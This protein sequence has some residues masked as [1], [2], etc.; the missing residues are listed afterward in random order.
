[1]CRHTFQI[2]RIGLVR[3]INRHKSWQ[4]NLWWFPTLHGPGYRFFP[5][6]GKDS[7]VTHVCISLPWCLA[8]RCQLWRQ[9]WN[10][11]RCLFFEKTGPGSHH[12]C[13]NTV[14][15]IISSDSSLDT[16]S[17]MLCEIKPCSY[18]VLCSLSSVST[19]HSSFLASC[20]GEPPFGF[21]FWKGGVDRRTGWIWCTCDLVQVM[22]VCCPK[23]WELSG[24]KTQAG[25]HTS[26]SRL[27]RFGTFQVLTWYYITLVLLQRWGWYQL[28]FS[29]KKKD[30]YT[31]THT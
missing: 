25:L 22:F 19:T 15:S 17:P 30:T 27:F 24:M 4:C 14:T 3:Q 13:W 1:M 20:F 9:T 29:I 12:S 6:C 2:L 11:C 16:P 23:Q 18:I 31:H 5:Y 7:W 28:E 8:C 21:P 26:E 10:S